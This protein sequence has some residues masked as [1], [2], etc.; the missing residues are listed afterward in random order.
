MQFVGFLLLTGF[1]DALRYN[2][3]C[4]CIIN[5]GGRNGNV[6]LLELQ[7]LLVIM[8]NWDWKAPFSGFRSGAA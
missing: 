6:E 8:C 3:V 7:C 5:E 1:R 2:C 4:V